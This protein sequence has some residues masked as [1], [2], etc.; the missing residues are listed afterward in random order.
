MAWRGM[1]TAVTVDE[2]V[3]WLRKRGK[4]SVREGMARYAIPADRA[5]GIAVG[6]LRA[7]GKQLGRD[8]ALAA[9][10]WKAGWYEARMLACFVDDPAAVSIAQM[11]RWARDFDSWA[12][13]DTACFHLFDKTPHAFGRVEAW[14][15]R[16]AEYE[17][18]AAFALLASLATHDKQTGDAAF[19]TGLALCRAA[20]DDER[21]FVRKAVSWALRA[22]GQRSRGLNEATLG[23]A[24]ELAA[25]DEA[26][27]RAIGKE[28][29]REL[30]RPAAAKRLA[31]AATR[32]APR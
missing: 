30:A 2:C 4:R 23:L 24:R 21:N 7:L 31:R 17:K 28:V 32:A 10:L 12:I 26:T 11:D 29:L 8:H 1:L 13:C 22:V 14:S 6:E 9:G 20:A 3:A 27:P 19:A 15:Q 5:F 25:R 18:R 16:K